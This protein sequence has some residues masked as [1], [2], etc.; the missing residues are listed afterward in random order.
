MHT[1]SRKKE[2]N[3]KTEE[4]SRRHKPKKSRIISLSEANTV[5][6]WGISSSFLI[7][8]FACVLPA[9]MYTCFACTHI[10]KPY[11]LLESSEAKRGPWIPCEQV[12]DRREPSVGAGNQTLMLHRNSECSELLSHHSPLGVLSFKHV[13]TSYCVWCGGG[14]E[15]G[16]CRSCHTEGRR[17]VRRVAFLLPSLSSASGHS[18]VRQ[19]SNVKHHWE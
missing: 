13:F 10:Y 19:P 16:V 7:F 14:G 9:C 8:L 18:E 2:R 15:R 1:C 4:R 6:S 11:V 3:I 17:P 5:V 12:L